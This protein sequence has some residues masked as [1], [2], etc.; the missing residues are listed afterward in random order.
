MTASPELRR[1]A[2]AVSLGRALAADI[3]DRIAAAF[4]RGERFLLGCPGGRTPTTTY[5]ALADE[6]A[7]RRI[8][9]HALVI[10]MMD[11]YVQ[12]EQDTW[13]HVP[14]DAH[15]S[16]R[17]FAREDIQEVLT[18]AVPLEH[19]LPDANVWFPNPADPAAYDDRIRN[20]GGIDFFI[21]ASGA[22][23]GHVAFNPPGSAEDSGSRIVQ[24]AE[25]TRLDNVA[26]FPEFGSVDA[27]PTHGV[28]VGIRTI[29]EHSRAAAMV[30]IGTDKRY[31][32]SRLTE[33]RG[34]DASWP[35]TVFRLVGETALYADDAAA[36]T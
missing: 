33:G 4:T 35:A 5:A 2:D 31:A 18:G 22:G 3:A 9:L 14:A 21:L 23:D 25:Q 8:D 26:T 15:N 30:V 6:V 36:G 12:R 1:F 20:A 11:D 7:R 32:F 27:V 29:A 16:C 17:R 34:Y 28:T 10:V 13:Q 24:L 19:A